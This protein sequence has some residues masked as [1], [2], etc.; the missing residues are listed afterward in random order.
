[1]KGL[2]ATTDLV[3]FHWSYA[4]VVIFKRSDHWHRTNSVSIVLDTI[5]T[6]L[7]VLERSDS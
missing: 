3:V 4:H 6:K 2:T 5:I 7:V 1:M